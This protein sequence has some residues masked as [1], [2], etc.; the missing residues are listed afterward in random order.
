[1]LL[2]NGV[3]DAMLNGLA[4]YLEAA[5]NVVIDVYAAD[6]VLTQLVMPVD[7]VKSVQNGVITFNAAEQAQVVKTG[8]PDIA[9]L[10]VDGSI[11]IELVVG[12]DLLLDDTTI[13]KGGYFKITEISINI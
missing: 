6:E 13:Y 8:Q 12:V 11:E 4:S 7:I 3:K 5:T 1:M 10:V 9:K 2:G